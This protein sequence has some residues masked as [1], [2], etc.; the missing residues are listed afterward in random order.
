MVKGLGHFVI[1][2]LLAT[3]CST[4]LIAGEPVEE[5]GKLTQA[6]EDESVFEIRGSRNL[7]GAIGIVSQSGNEVEV[8]FRK[9]ARAETQAQA[10]RFL[11]LIDVRLQ[12]TDPDR[13]S[14]SILTPS[15]SPWAGSDY[16]VSLDILVR[17]PEKMKIEGQAQFMQLNVRGPFAGV[18]FHSEFSPLNLQGLS[19]PIDIA[20]SFAAVEL[21]D[22]TGSVTAETRY[23]A[24]KATNIT[25]PLGTAI[26]KNTGGVIT[27]KDIQ[28]PVEA[29]TSYSTIDAS[30][31]DAAEGSIVLRTSYSPINVSG[32]S[33]ELICETS[34]SPINIVDGDL[35]H[36]QSKIE[37]SYSPISA[38]LSNIDGSKLF[39]YNNYNNINLSVPTDISSQVV[40]SVDEG[41][42]I[43]ATNLPVKPTFLDVTR[44]E[45]L[46]GD[47]RGWIELKVSGIGKINIEGR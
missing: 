34:F 9:Q 4:V 23:G 35:T 17:L 6:L 24:M 22:I 21:S 15:D 7:N 5:T 29:Y 11:D 32:V 42:R 8:T 46:L 2:A 14:L 47:G 1:I 39:I 45:G 44:L 12:S 36:G 30:D 33:G 38:E 19:G 41:G 37:T 28:G 16:Q 18:S 31:I 20:T 43:R 26:F 10:K 3:A 13:V 25:I 40:A 27:L